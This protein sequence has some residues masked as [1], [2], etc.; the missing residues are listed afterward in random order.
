MWSKRRNITGLSAAHV[1]AGCVVGPKLPQEVRRRSEVASLETCRKSLEDR[2]EKFECCVSL[3]SI[4][5]ESCE[6]DAG[7]Q[8]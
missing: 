7:T 5:P 6:S 3:R 1:F 8:L 2:V 4:S